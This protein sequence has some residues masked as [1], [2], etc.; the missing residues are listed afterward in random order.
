MSTTVSASTSTPYVAQPRSRSWVAPTGTSHP[1]CVSCSFEVAY[2]PRLTKVIERQSQPIDMACAHIV[3]R[4]WFDCLI[5]GYRTGEETVVVATE[6]V[7]PFLTA[8]SYH[9]HCCCR[10]HTAYLDGT[11][12]MDGHADDCVLM[13]DVISPCDNETTR[14]VAGLLRQ[15]RD[16]VFGG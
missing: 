12:R 5:C 16:E 11:Y 4:S 7:E 10:R 3:E 1:T 6:L 14:I 2:A 9:D 15:V 8:E 13:S